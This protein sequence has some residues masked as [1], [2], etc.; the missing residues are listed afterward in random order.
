M[1]QG[2]IEIEADV[3]CCCASCGKSEIDDIKWRNCTACYLVRYCSDECMEEHKTRH[4]EECTKRATELFDKILF[5][6]PESTHLGDCPICSLPLP[7]DEK[8]S[9]IYDCCSKLICNGCHH[10]NQNRE[11]E[12]R[13]QHTCPFCRKPSPETD[14]E[15]FKRTMKR[16]EANDPVALCE[17]GVKQRK[18]GNYSKAFEYWTKA[19]KLGFADAHYELSVMYHAGE[20]VEKDEEKEVFHKEVAAILGCPDARYNLGVDEWVRNNNAG[21]AVK[22]FIIAATQGDD[23]SIKWL[24]E[25]F[26]RGLVIKEDLAAALRAHK[27]AVDATKSP[28]REAAEKYRR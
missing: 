15:C 8:K 17:E 23:D 1:S 19:A 2:I 9:T 18:K 20:G 24:M 27:A 16:I 4:A 26:R 5:K 28:Q 21:R 14:E 7:L 11:I 13:L 10:A 6:Q 12:M 25:A 22:H 3:S